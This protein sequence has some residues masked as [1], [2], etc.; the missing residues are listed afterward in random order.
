MRRKLISPFPR[1]PQWLW[2]TV[3]V[4]WVASLLIALSCNE[5]GYE[6]IRLLAAVTV[7]TAL[8]ANHWRYQPLKTWKTLVVIVAESIVDLLKVAIFVVIAYTSV[9]L[10][11]PTYQCYNNRAKIVEMMAVGGS[12][13]RGEIEQRAKANSTL[14][15]AGEGLKVRPLSND[16]EGFVTSNGIIVLASKNPPAVVVFEPHL[17]GNQINW[18][19]RGAPLSLVPASCRSE[20]EP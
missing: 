2:V 18:T 20:I 8:W 1:S 17:A 9:A 7:S 4:V 12:D 11:L 15:S 5:R 13:L 19:C 3:V 6:I 16:A 10:F 14:E